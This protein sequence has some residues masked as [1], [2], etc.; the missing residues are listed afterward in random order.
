[1][2]NPQRGSHVLTFAARCIPHPGHTKI[3][4]NNRLAG[5]WLKDQSR[6]KTLKGTHEKGVT[7]RRKYQRTYSTMKTVLQLICMPKSFTCNSPSRRWAPST[8]L[9]S[10]S[11]VRGF[12]SP[13]TV[14]FCRAGP[15][16]SK[17]SIETPREKFDITK[18]HRKSVWIL[19]MEVWPSPPDRFK[20]TY[21]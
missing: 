18:R 11:S 12:L 10:V 6:C 3:E 4:G 14:I 8:A 17:R 7:S 1:M 9:S 21:I 15:N 20:V 16:Y 13:L 5:E 2:N 19:R